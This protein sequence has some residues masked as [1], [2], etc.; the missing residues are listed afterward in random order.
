MK[1]F[2]RKWGNGIGIR[3][4]KEVLEKLMIS[5]G[6]EID[7]QANGNNI[8]LTK[9]SSVMDINDLTL[10]MDPGDPHVIEL[11]SEL[12]NEKIEGWNT[13]RT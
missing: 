13:S 8:I 10:G 5:E 4:P 1:I 12:G 3:F 6:S 7:I 9:Q 2:A 11:D